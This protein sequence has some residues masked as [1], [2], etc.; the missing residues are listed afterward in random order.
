MDNVSIKERDCIKYLGVLIENKFIAG[1][2]KQHSLY[3]NVKI[4]RGIRILT[5]IRHSV[6]T[7]VLKQLY[8][9]I[10]APHISYALVIW[11]SASYCAAKS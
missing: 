1:N 7:E 6:S 2:W 4:S 5:K 9:V 8:L 10:I 11:C 3:V